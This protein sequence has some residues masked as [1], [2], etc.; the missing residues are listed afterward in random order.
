MQSS[1]EKDKR[2]IIPKEKKDTKLQNKVQSVCVNE[3]VR[4]PVQKPKLKEG[5]NN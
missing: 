2:G 5:L 4:K 1:K 3:I